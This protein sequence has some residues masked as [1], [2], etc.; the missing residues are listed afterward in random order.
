MFPEYQDHL[1][2][3]RPTCHTSK[4]TAEQTQLDEQTAVCQLKF[5]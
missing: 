5:L 4:L 3:L 1:K 2:T